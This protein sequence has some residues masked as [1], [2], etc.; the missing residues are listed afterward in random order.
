MNKTPRLL[1]AIG[2][3]KGEVMKLV[4][5][6]GYDDLNLRDVTS[7]ASPYATYF[8]SYP[9]HNEDGKGKVVVLSNAMEGHR[10]DWNEVLTKALGRRLWRRYVNNV[11]SNEERIEAHKVIVAELVPDYV[12]TVGGIMDMQAQFGGS[13]T[14]DEVQKRRLAYFFLRL[15]DDPGVAEQMLCVYE[16]N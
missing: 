10:V 15:T 12:A 6:A 7:E 11:A 2:L 9:E 5:D 14:P 3:S 8:Q 4:E 16:V 1:L 13:S